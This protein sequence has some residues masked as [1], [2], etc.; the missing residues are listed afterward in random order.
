MNI[1]NYSTEWDTLQS[2]ALVY[3]AVMLFFG[4]TATGIKLYIF[5]SDNEKRVESMK[6]LLWVVLGAIIIINAMAFAGLITNGLHETVET[7]GHPTENTSMS[8]GSEFEY[9]PAG[10]GLIVTA[11]LDAGAL[12]VDTAISIRDSILGEEL[13]LMEYLFDNTNP[14]VN[15]RIP[16]SS[17]SLYASMVAYSF[18]IYMY[19]FINV[20]AS[21]LKSPLSSQA[22]TDAAEQA[23][24]LIYATIMTILAI[25]TYQ[26]L[27][28]VTDDLL[29]I[30]N[31]SVGDIGASAISGFNRD[32]AGLTGIIAQMYMAFL[33]FKIWLIFMSRAVVINVFY[34]LTPLAFAIYGANRNFETVSAWF[35][36][37]IKFIFLPFYYAVI[38]LV[39]T[40]ILEQMPN[41]NNPVIIIIMYGTVFSVAN[42]LK[43]MFQLN[44]IGGRMQQDAN[45]GGAGL[46]MGAGMVMMAT[47]KGGKKGGGIVNAAKSITGKSSGNIRTGAS[48]ISNALRNTAIGSKVANSRAVATMTDRLGKVASGASNVMSHVANSPQAQVLKGAGQ[49][50]AGVLGSKP[51]RAA[52]LL[53]LGGSAGAVAGIMG[54]PGAGIAAAAGVG[55]VVSGSLGGL[56]NIGKKPAEAKSNMESSSNPGKSIQS[57]PFKNQQANSMGQTGTGDRM[58]RGSST[59]SRS[60]ASGNQPSRAARPQS[61]PMS[62]SDH[63]YSNRNR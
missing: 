16:G 55:R 25:P 40:M 33:E 32:T 23:R 50:T 44:S 3:G 26:L 38:L 15:M 59:P 30:V 58:A 28:I 6:T 56:Q 63:K 27:C 8:G 34:V 49:M 21:L 54:G 7:V 11:L 39:I 29:T 2:I 57:S 24:L 10:E 5:R 18:I 41:G 61:R 51:V 17:M 60:S 31:S 12:F 53:A 62:T 19:G 36:V 14:L 43:T 46:L 48:T 52:A 22:R 45:T 37:M 1:F 9:D 35:N 20:G 13:S 47:M 42:M 4:V